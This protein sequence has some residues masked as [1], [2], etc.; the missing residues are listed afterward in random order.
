MQK[1]K[2]AGTLIQEAT[3]DGMKKSLSVYDQYFQTKSVN[4]EPL[5]KHL[6]MQL[7]PLPAI[8]LPIV[9]QDKLIE[10]ESRD[11]E[12]N[13]CDDTSLNGDSIS[14]S[15]AAVVVANVK[16]G[17]GRPPKNPSIDGATAN[18]E[19]KSGK[20]IRSVSSNENFGKYRFITHGFPGLKR[21]KSLEKNKAASL[22]TINGN[23]EVE[24]FSLPD[25]NS[26]TD[27][28]SLVATTLRKSMGGAQ[29][30]VTSLNDIGYNGYLQ[31]SFLEVNNPL[32]SLLVE[33]VNIIN[34]LV[35]GPN[36]VC[37][38]S[39]P[40]F[41]APA[42][43]RD[44][45]YSYCTPNEYIQ[46]L[47]FRNDENFDPILPTKFRSRCRIGRNGRLIVDRVPVRCCS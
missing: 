8:P 13:I 15:Q 21:K 12:L 1:L 37:R 42:A 38:P 30:V 19:K 45:F 43:A 10:G 26:I 22:Y 23:G 34:D 7:P 25:T 46:A 27:Q 28:G 32:E 14:T 35:D 6:W 18:S 9:I 40:H 24:I 36:T 41:F 20:P 11:A 44:Q 2:D 17:A 4:Y 33:G 16:K 29:D 39:W 3:D 47:E 31:P 5:Y